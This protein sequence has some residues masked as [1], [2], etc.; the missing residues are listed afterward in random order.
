MIDEAATLPAVSG[1][2]ALTRLADRLATLAPAQHPC[3][4]AHKNGETGEHVQ[5]SARVTVIFQLS[6]CRKR[7]GPGTSTGLRS[8][9]C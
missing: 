5:E 2:E 9:W 3:E 1:P 6:L 4:P 7:C 8:S